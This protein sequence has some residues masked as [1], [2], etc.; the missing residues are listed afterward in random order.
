MST[1]LCMYLKDGLGNFLDLLH[2]ELLQLD[3]CEIEL[4]RKKDAVTLFNAY[5]IMLADAL[6][7]GNCPLGDEFREKFNSKFS[8][9]IRL[10]H[11]YQLRGVSLSA[12]SR[13]LQALKRSLHRLAMAQTGNE[14]EKARLTVVLTTLAD[15][16]QAEIVADWEKVNLEQRFRNLE[17][18]NLQLSRERTTYK[19]IFASTSNLVM[20][21]DSLGTIIEANPKATTFFSSK[22]VLGQFCGVPLDRSEKQL[23]EFLSVFPPH[24]AHELPLQVDGSLYHFNL[25]IKPINDILPGQSGVILILSD[26]TCMVD[27]RQMLEQRIRE[28][29]R[30]LSS[31]EKLLGALFHAVGKGIILLDTDGEVV[32]AN[33]QASEMYGVPLEVLVGSNLDILTD[34]M[35]AATLRE[36]RQQ[37]LEGQRFSAEI[38]SMYADGAQFPC[39]VTMTRMDLDGVPMWPVIV[40]DITELKIMHKKLHEEKEQV[41]EMNVTLRNVLKSIETD[42]NDAEAK[43]KERILNSMLPGIE[44]IRDEENSNVR[45]GYLS[46]LREQVIALSEG[47]SAEL[48]GD[49]LKLSKTELK[50]CQFIK[51]GLS[52]KELC[53]ILNVSFETIQTH[54]KN[55]RRKLGLKGKKN[56]L[57]QY[58]A[59]RSCDFNL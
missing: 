47:S 38:I 8:T 55:I 9:I 35:G 54:R 59:T 33:H 27:H 45:E 24:Q 37:L 20:I 48:D 32:K 14:T 44:K 53:E 13:Y 6:V 17:S 23:L 16:I 57:Y 46:L 31:S 42:R 10:R 50:I 12:F 25:Q 11:F 43:L 41:E 36:A 4:F 29:T 19:N 34:T 56:S 21:T 52:G 40:R 49:L 51:A 39:E 28:R 2:H 58:L 30:A 7:T 3:M 1:K 26:V 15:V 18:S 22:K 5:L